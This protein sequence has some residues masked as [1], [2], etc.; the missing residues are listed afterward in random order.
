MKTVP[1]NKAEALA[2]RKVVYAIPGSD[3]SAAETG[4]VI[5]VDSGLAWVHWQDGNNKLY[6]TYSLSHFDLTPPT[7]RPVDLLALNW[8]SI[9]VW[10]KKDPCLVLVTALRRD[11]GFLFGGSWEYFHPS[12][13]PSL[14]YAPTPAGP[15]RPMME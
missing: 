8:P 6:P 14:E 7:P 3:L 4:L 11:G 5:A 15:W 9:W 12:K 2:G 13:E 10:S 1:F